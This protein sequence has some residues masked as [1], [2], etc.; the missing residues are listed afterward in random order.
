MFTND[1]YFPQDYTKTNRKFK[2]LNLTYS[3]LKKLKMIEKNNSTLILPEKYK[4]NLSNIYERF[5]EELI[6]FEAEFNKY[7]NTQ[8]SKNSSYSKSKIDKIID[9]LSLKETKRIMELKQVV[10]LNFNYTSILERNHQPQELRNISMI[11][12]NIHGRLSGDDL[13]NTNIIFGID[14][15]N[16]S[17]GDKA[18]PFT[19]TYRVINNN[20]MNT[21]YE[22]T[23][24]PS[25]LEYIYFYGHSLGE[26][27]Y[28]YFQSLF[29]TV[30]L[31]SGKTVL[32]F[33]YNDDYL[34]TKEEKLKL[35]KEININVSLLLESYGKSFKQ[36][37]TKGKNLLHRLIL[38]NRI[39]I[40]NLDE[41]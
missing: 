37:K 40:I 17:A 5:K 25:D 13:K 6:L 38:E 32:R 9:I 15:L 16:I 10:L 1:K 31:Y 23:S 4:I 26:Q 41:V 12:R 2:E 21:F 30:N 28:S 36:E 20:I 39:E 3:I 29:D 7:M 11:E 27:D 22:I 24:I 8:I 35:K 34:E 33:V 19:K 18:Y 14:S